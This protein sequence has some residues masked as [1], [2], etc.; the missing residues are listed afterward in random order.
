MYKNFILKV[1][2]LFIIVIII[3]AGFNFFIDPCYHY[4]KPWFGLKPAYLSQSYQNIGMA[5]N[6]DYNTLILGSSMTENFKV[7]QFNTLFNCNSIKLSYEGAYIKNNTILLD[8]V[9]PHKNIQN[10]FMSIDDY[11]FKVALDKEP[12][13]STPDYLIDENIFNDVKYLL[14][15]SIFLKYTLP[16]LESNLKDNNLNCDLAYNWNSYVVFGKKSILNK[17]K[18]PSINKNKN[19]DY[20]QHI[21]NIKDNAFEL[22]E[23]AK[24]Y[25]N[26]KFYFFIPPYSIVYWDKEYRAG[27]VDEDIEMY[28]IIA[29]ILLEYGNIELYQ[30]QNNYEIVTNLNNYKD[31][32]HYS[33]KINE[34]MVKAI[35]NGEFKLTKENYIEKLDELKNFINNYNYDSIFE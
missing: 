26:T 34:Y 8:K 1:I 31:Y 14:N 24:N 30:F 20:D 18:R 15:K 12:K 7:S 16:M 19:K 22:A 33:E 29:N 10:I 6:F 23:Y 28:K 3:F 32:Q 21:K 25:K 9:L 2:V 27:L 4:H 13:N 5:K 35:K 17:Y 11:A